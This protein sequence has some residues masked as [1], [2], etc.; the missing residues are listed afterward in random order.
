MRLTE[1]KAGQKETMAQPKRNHGRSPKK[2][3]TRAQGASSAVQPAGCGAIWRAAS[4]ISRTV[5]L[6][7]GQDLMSKPL[8]LHVEEA[9]QQYRAAKNAARKAVQ[10]GRRLYWQQ[11]AIQLG[12]LFGKSDL[13]AASR[14]V[15]LGTDATGKPRIMPRNIRRVDGDIVCARPKRKR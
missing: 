4:P 11:K 8:Q 15:K 9:R 12:H 2:S 3:Q 10:R 6:S 7:Y 13:Q 1:N 14:K 5:A